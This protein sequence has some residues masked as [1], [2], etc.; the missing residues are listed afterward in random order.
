M[1]I[2]TCRIVAVII[3]VRD[4]MSTVSTEMKVIRVAAVMVVVIKREMMLEGVC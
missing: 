3:E 1:I 2:E 4:K